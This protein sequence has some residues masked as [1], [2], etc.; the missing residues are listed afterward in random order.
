MS[1]KDVGLTAWTNLIGFHQDQNPLCLAK[2]VRLPLFL[3][4]DSAGQRQMSDYVDLLLH[5]TAALLA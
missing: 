4:V 1:L 5:V 2:Q 3:H